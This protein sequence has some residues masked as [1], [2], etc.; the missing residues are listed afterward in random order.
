MAHRIAALVSALPLTYAGMA[1][2]PAARQPAG[3]ADIAHRGASAHAPENTLAAFREAR[4]ANADYFELD[5]QQTRDHVP[6]IMHDATLGRTTDA[7]KVFPGRS[8]WR[9]G[10]FTLAQVKRL[11]AGS[12]FSPRYAGE[13]VP[14]LAETLREMEGSDMK[15]LLELKNP[16]L[17]PG[18]PGRVADELRAQPG[19][20]LP[21]RT[22]VQSFD[23]PSVESFHRLLP[24]VP[25]GV[26]GT[27][28]ARQLPAVARYA[29]Y[30]NPRYD[31]VTAA[32][33]RAVHA[34][35]MKVFAWVADSPATVR[36]LIGDRV[37]GI[38]S[39]RP[40][41]VPH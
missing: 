25:T 23:W 30:V 1:F 8:P 11:D 6:I 22:V 28:T 40:E 13:R 4:A 29:G 3:V 16:A 17:Y 36:R 34:R 20:T 18:L 15:L 26:I 9:V 12:W 10:D 21:D 14:T 27:P 24:S 32:Y 2:V 37:D 7:E 38:V 41:A 33:V 19:W 35:H 31:T 39:N 5:V